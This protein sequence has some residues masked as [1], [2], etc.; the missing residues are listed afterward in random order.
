MDQMTLLYI[1]AGAVIVSAVALVI[2]ACL[3]FGMYKA[4]ATLTGRIQT[5]LP[6]VDSLMDTSRTA[7]EEGRLTIAEILV[8]RHGQSRALRLG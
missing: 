3:L 5:M 8:K 6:K 4:T 7:I 2:Q 1:M